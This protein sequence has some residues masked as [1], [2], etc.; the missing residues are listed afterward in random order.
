M[1]FDDGDRGD[2]QKLHV[3]TGKNWCTEVTFTSLQKFLM[4]NDYA[5]N[6]ADDYFDRRKLSY[7]SGVVVSPFRI[8]VCEPRGRVTGDSRVI[9]SVCLT[10]GT[11]FC[12]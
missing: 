8:V 12:F 5:E 3:D 9:V 7:V 10:E 2:Q 11:L 6:N 4:G 1:A